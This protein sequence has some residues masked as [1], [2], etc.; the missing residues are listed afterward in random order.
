MIHPGTK[1]CRVS[2]AVETLLLDP[3]FWYHE[4]GCL[5]F[6]KIVGEYISGLV[7]F[8]DYFSCENKSSS[9]RI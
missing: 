8:V 7:V 9:L 5:W 4:S 3:Y 1:T 2:C 6:W